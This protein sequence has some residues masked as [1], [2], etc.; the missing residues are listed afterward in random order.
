MTCALTKDDRIIAIREG[1]A[2]AFGYDNIMETNIW[3]SP[4][5]REQILKAIEN[6]VEKAVTKYIDERVD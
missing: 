2:K 3:A 6:G 1:V 4:K 5:I